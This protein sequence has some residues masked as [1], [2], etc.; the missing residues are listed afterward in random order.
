MF[1]ANKIH[2]HSP[3]RSW[4]LESVVWI[5]LTPTL[6][7]CTQRTHLA[8]HWPCFF[9]IKTYPSHCLCSH[10]PAFHLKLLIWLKVAFVIV[11]KNQCIHPLSCVH[12]SRGLL[13]L[14][15][16]SICMCAI[17]QLAQAEVKQHQTNSNQLTAGVTPLC[18][19][20]GHIQ[21]MKEACYCFSKLQSHNVKCT[22]VFFGL[23]QRINQMNS[24][25]YK[26]IFR[27]E[28]GLDFWVTWSKG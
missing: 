5:V 24:S 8:L 22:S 1:P 6:K 17:C 23:N 7:D 19:G 27:I 18:R 28:V 4:A 14:K 21:P 26:S 12:K 16:L 13:G 20:T 9:F 15:T 10:S 25:F 2:L 3:A 11:K